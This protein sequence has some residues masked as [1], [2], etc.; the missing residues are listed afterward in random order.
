MLESWRKIFAFGLMVSLSMSVAI[1]SASAADILKIGV[2]GPFTGGSAK[3]GEEIKRATTL[4]FEDIGNK[5]GDYTLEPVWIDSQSDPAKATNAYAEAVERKGVQVGLM[6]WHSSVALAVM[7]LAAKY[8]IPHL[9][10]G[11]AS[12]NINEKY[13]SNPE[14]YAGYWLKSWPVPLDTMLGYIDFL[15]SAIADGTLKVDKKTVVLFGEDTDWGRDIVNGGRD[16]FTKHGWEILSED[17]ISTTQTEFYPLLTKWKEMKPA[18]IFGSHGFLAAISSLIKQ[19]KEVGLNAPMICEGLGWAGEWYSLTGPSSDGV[20]D[21]IHKLATPQA[22][23]FSDKFEKKYGVKPSPSSGGLAWDSS[24]FFIK[25]AKRT[26]EKYGKLDAENI[27]AVTV[28][29]VL[30][31]QMT[32]TADEGAVTVKRF[33]YTAESL[34]DPVIGQEDWAMP[35]I[36]YKGGQGMI[37]FPKALAEKEFEAAR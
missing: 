22:K 30:T 17:M 10:G 9:F 29:E 21:M 25:I 34:P 4:A 28:D 15:E 35:V 33:R 8:K 23:V 11:G 26:L 32:Y 19:S 37:V 2:I 24:N 6:N 1:T 27:R 18:V 5:I 3:T 20:I 31:G 14:K 36:Q 7:D 12:S 13:R 16:M